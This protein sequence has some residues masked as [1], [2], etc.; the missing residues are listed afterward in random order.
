MFLDDQPE[1]LAADLQIAREKTYAL[2]DEISY[3]PG[4]RQMLKEVIQAR[5]LASELSLK[6]ANA[7]MLYSGARGYLHGGKVE[8]SYVKPILWQS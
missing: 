5:I 6:A 1:E 2:A 4:D 3:Q 7:A 8:E